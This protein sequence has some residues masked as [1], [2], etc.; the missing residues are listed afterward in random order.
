MYINLFRVYFYYDVCTPFFNLSLQIFGQIGF[1]SATFILV[2]RG[3]MPN[4]ASKFLKILIL[5]FLL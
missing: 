5:Q 1:L 3:I 4:E 2:V